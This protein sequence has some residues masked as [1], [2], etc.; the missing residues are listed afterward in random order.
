MVQLTRIKNWKPV[1]WLNI[2]LMLTWH[3]IMPSHAKAD[4]IKVRCVE[5]DNTT[6]TPYLA[7]LYA[8]ALMPSY[9][10]NNSEYKALVKLWNAES[11]WRNK[12]FNKVKVN[13]ENAGGIPQILGMDPATPATEQI[14]SGLAYIKHRYG[15][16]SVAWA[17]HRKNNW[18]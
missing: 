12:A 8:K 7:R 9:G 5:I 6:F 14:A 13:G 11:H 3:A 1:V 18:Y 16:P 2:L 17:H 10:W 15:K 4:A